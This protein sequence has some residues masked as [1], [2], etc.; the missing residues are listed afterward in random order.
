[1]D[2]NNLD[3]SDHDVIFIKS[4]LGDGRDPLVEWQQGQYNG[5]W[6]A[7]GAILMAESLLLVA[8]MS[9]AEAY[10][11]HEMVSKLEEAIPGVETHEAK[12]W[13]SIRSAR[14]LDMKC[15]RPIF[16]HRTRQPLVEIGWYKTTRTVSIE[17]AIQEAGLIVSAANTAI[18]DASL[19]EV[20]RARGFSDEDRDA[21]FSEI[22]TSRNSLEK[23]S[24]D[25][26]A[27]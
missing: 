3:M 7:E 11:A 5:C 24:E 17:G 13:S 26:A 4:A 9:F 21:F 25:K 19:A 15:L 14:I 22:L 23:K 2:Q 1:M 8:G 27:N 16:G 10:I 18:M 12:V 20:L 6:D